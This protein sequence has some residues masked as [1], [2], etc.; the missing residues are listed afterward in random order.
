MNSYVKNQIDFSMVVW[1]INELKENE[2]IEEK[3][4]EFLLS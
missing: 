2:W 1:R 3:N 4:M